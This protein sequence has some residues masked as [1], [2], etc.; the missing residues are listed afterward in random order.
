V[1]SALGLLHTD[2]KALLHGAHH[3]VRGAV[4]KV[5]DTR[6]GAIALGNSRSRGGVSLV[7]STEIETRRARP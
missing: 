6:V 7:G 4:T 3:L 5:Q 2:A 1:R